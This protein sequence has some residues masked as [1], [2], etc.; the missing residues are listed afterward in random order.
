VRGLVR[1]SAGFDE[2]VKDDGDDD[3]TAADADQA[4]EQ[5]APPPETMPKR[6]SQKVLIAP[7]IPVLILKKPRNRPIR[8]VHRADRAG[9]GLFVKTLV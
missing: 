9:S 3:G 7:R 4:S 6:T 2:P 5:S 8:K 1:R